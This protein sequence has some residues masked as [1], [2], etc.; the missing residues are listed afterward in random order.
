MTASVSDANIVPRSLKYSANL[1]CAVGIPY[2]FAQ[3]KLAWALAGRRFRRAA[4]NLS[5]RIEWRPPADF[6]KQGGF[7]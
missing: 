4:I 1:P 2:V 7:P 6:A 5:L 3:S